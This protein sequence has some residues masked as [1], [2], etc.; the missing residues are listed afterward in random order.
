MFMRNKWRQS[1]TAYDAVIYISIASYRDIFL[2]KTIDSIFSSAYNPERVRVGCFVQLYNFDTAAFVAN[3]HNKKVKAK[4]QTPGTVFSVTKCRNYANYW[5]D[6]THDFCLQIDSHCRFE[7]NWDVLLCSYIETLNS[8][9]AVISAYPPLWG[10]DKNGCEYFDP[11]SEHFY[12]DVVYDGTVTQMAL[13]ATYEIVGERILKP[14]QECMNEA[15]HVSGSFIFS[16]P[17]YFKECRQSEIIT[18]WGEE[19]CASI[20]TFTSGWDVFAPTYTPLYHLYPVNDKYLNK[21]IYG[22][23]YGSDKIWRDFPNVWNASKTISTKKIIN[24]LIQ[25]PNHSEIFGIKRDV[26]SLYEKLG[27]DIGSILYEY[28]S[29]LHKI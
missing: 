23:E 17:E 21:I 10:F 2:Q 18:F 20:K 22:S 25:K 28:D 9:T 6:D 15:W 19:L 7:Q 13:E 14:T 24:A 8:E 5:L 3:D 11:Q 26:A 12:D 16:R 27:Y 1:K 29:K 4:Y